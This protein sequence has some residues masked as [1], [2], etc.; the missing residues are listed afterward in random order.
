MVVAL[1]V[2]RLPSYLTASLRPWRARPAA[3]PSSSRVPSDDTSPV[4]CP[5]PARAPAPGDASCPGAQSPE[6][7]VDSSLAQVN[8]VP[9]SGGDS[10]GPY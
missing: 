9:S 8:V 6:S 2:A 3:G 1:L 5:P 7:D 4:P 10:Q